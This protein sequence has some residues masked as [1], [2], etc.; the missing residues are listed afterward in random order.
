MTF[1]C[2]IWLKAQ[3][4]CSM[5][6]CDRKNSAS[7]V[8]P[9]VFA[10]CHGRYHCS[11]G[12]TTPQE[13]YHILLAS[14]GIPLV[15]SGE[16]VAKRWPARVMSP[17]PAWRRRRS[18]GLYQFSQKKWVEFLCS[19]RSKTK[20]VVTNSSCKKLGYLFRGLRNR[21]GD[22]RIRISMFGRASAR[23]SISSYPE[24][25]HFWLIKSR[26]SIYQCD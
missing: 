21:S 17:T 14:S 11:F 4:C 8:P 10:S 5:M 19:R 3:T 6:W 7:R 15:V 22:Q 24:I 13:G 18:T 12:G 1:L 9:C 20:V 25:S 26:I 16:K 23:R 2:H